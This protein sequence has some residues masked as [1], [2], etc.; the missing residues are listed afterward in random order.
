[1]V[2]RTVL[3]R[4][5]LISL[6][7]V[8]PVNTVQPRTA[9]NN[10]GPMKNV[11]NNAYSTARRP[12]NNRTT[13]RNSKINQKVNNVR[14]TH[15]NTARPKVNTARP[16]VNTARP[17]AVINAVQE[18]H[19]NVVKASACWVWRPKH[20][21]LDH[22]SRNNGASISFRRFNY[23]DAQGR[24]K[25]WLGSPKETNF[26]TIISKDFPS[27]EFKLPGEEEKKDAEDPG[28]EDSEV[29]STEEPR[30]NQENDENVN[31]T[32][33]INT[34]SPA[35]NTA[36]I[37][38]NVVGENIV[39]GCADDPNMHALEE[40]GSFS[41]AENDDSGADMNNFDTYF[42]VNH[43]PTTRIH[44]DHPINQM[45]VKSAFLYG[46][47]EEEVYA[48]QPPGFE[49]PNFPNIVYKVEKALY[50]LHQA[51]KAWKE[52][53]T[54]YEKIMHKK[55]QMS[56][57]GELTFF[58]GMETISTPMKTKKPL[59]KDEDG[60]DIDEHLYRS[61]IG[62]LMYLISSRLDIMFV[63][64]ACARFQVNPKISH[65]YVVKRIFRHLKGQPKLG[66]WYPK[67]SP[68]DLAAYTNS[69]YVE[70]SL[71]RK[72]I[73][74]GCQFL[75]CRLISWQCKKQTVVANSITEAEY[76]A[77]SNCCGQTTVK[78]KNIN[79]EAQIHAKVDGKKV[80]IFEA[81]IRRDLK[82]EEEGGVDCLSNE[83]IFE[84]L[85]L[86]GIK[87]SDEEHSLDASKQ[88]RKIDDIDADKDISLVNVQD[89]QDMFD[90]KDDLGGEEVFVTQQGATVVEKDVDAAQDQVTTAATTTAGTTPTISMDEITL[91]KELIEI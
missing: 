3:T 35:D 23:I 32:N 78:V 68:F 73:I 63:V 82:F 71:D 18:N 61:M 26:L 84:Q 13:S 36:G 15:V 24:S 10:A 44:K 2:S 66:L 83:I 56:S 6:N 37:K 81:L 57:I 88:G 76:I 65:L 38:D 54:E 39:Y 58:L 20:N 53:C 5:G 30:V 4:S 48:C 87:S 46:K 85:T 59:L 64:C 72:Y 69:D 50:G 8:R 16:K 90:V 43:V 41:D 91:T 47:I 70:A 11:I 51:P 67:D 21:V 49:D 34:V 74:G 45:D 1:M 60:V 89:N 22:V 80:I 77:A 42:Q 7:T 31:S 19:V 40:I 14:A 17:K 52:M 28:N 29:P 86:I 55:F 27:A 75:G 33:N 25:S 9:V 12:I 79:E 62:S